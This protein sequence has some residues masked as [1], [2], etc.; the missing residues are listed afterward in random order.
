MTQWII[1][2]LRGEVAPL[3]SETTPR[4]KLTLIRDHLI[5]YLLH[6]LRK[7]LIQRCPYPPDRLIVHRVPVREL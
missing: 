5:P 7:G 3:G 4:S 2:S 1:G 6:R